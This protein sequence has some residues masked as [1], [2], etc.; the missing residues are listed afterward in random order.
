MCPRTD[1]SRLME[2]DL[3]AGCDPEPGYYR[4]FKPLKSTNIFSELF[5]S[6]RI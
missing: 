1:G 5:L 2:E 4:Y 6:I 3:G